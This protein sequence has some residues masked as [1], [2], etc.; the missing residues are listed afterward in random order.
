MTGAR[1]IRQVR[2]TLRLSALLI[3]AAPA[4]AM[5]CTAPGNPPRCPPGLPLDPALRLGP[6]TR[7][8]VNALIGTP[9]P[10]IVDQVT[11]DTART[12]EAIRRS[13]PPVI[14]YPPARPH[15]EGK[16]ETP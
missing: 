7:D 8:D 1:A 16:G 2:A 4:S 12:W 5:A 9:G 10:P 3:L 6:M 15:M 11:R 14:A 13:P